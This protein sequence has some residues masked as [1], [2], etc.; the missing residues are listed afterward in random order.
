MQRK[1]LIIDDEKDLCTMIVRYL[2]RKEYAVECAHTL[3]NGM[4]KLNDI[5]PDILLLDNNLPDGLGWKEADK[6]QRLYPEMQITLISAN[7]ATP[8]S[9]MAYGLGFQK[10]EKPITFKTLDAYL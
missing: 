8:Y 2:T 10:M 4:H 9:I 1:V 5:H 3:E 6:I 7:E